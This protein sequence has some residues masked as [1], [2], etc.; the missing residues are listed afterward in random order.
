MDDI[1]NTLEQRLRELHDALA[2]TDDAIQRLEL[3]AEIH[4][5]DDR[6]AR[7]D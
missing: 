2:S 1:Q 3:L 5:V 7:L 4:S 6:L